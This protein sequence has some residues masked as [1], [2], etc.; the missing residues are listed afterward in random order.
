MDADN[1]SHGF[2][3][4][5]DSCLQGAWRKNPPH[6]KYAVSRELLIPVAKYYI[7]LDNKRQAEIAQATY[8]SHVAKGGGWYCPVCN[9]TFS[10]SPGEAPVCKHMTREAKRIQEKLVNAISIAMTLMSE[11]NAIKF[12]D[13]VET[14]H[15]SVDD[16]EDKQ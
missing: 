11:E 7:D 16:H 14:L 13:M 5:C 2:D 15:L 9:D 3:C 4:L 1:V 10:S 8:N 12:A 6:P